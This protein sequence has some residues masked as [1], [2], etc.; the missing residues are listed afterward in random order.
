MIAVAP[1]FC[2]SESAAWTP[3]FLDLLPQIRRTAACSFRGLNREAREE[4]IQEVVATAFTWYDRL[5][6]SGR[7]ALVY[8]GPL[9]TFAVRHVRSGRTCA[10][11]L[12]GRDL[13]SSYRRD[14]T[15][16]A[17]RRPAPRRDTEWQAT[18]VEDRR[19]GPAETAAAR[20]DFAGWL[21]TLSPRRRRLARVLAAGESTRVAAE[22]FGVTA[23]RI[24]QQRRELEASWRC[25]QGGTPQSVRL[26]TITTSSRKDPSC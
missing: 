12:N 8:A 22:R 19:A 4:A 6:R 1:P 20:I 18:L 7:G 21:K 10:S 13:M 23:G 16:A 25:F 17:I 9:A 2:L 5:V 26:P 3:D 24:S 11:R 15:T 14:R